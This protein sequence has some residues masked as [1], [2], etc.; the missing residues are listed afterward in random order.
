MNL[1]WGGLSDVF[2][3]HATL[4]GGHDENGFVFTVDENGKVVFVSDVATGFDVEVS[5]EFSFLSGLDGH[6]DV[7]EDVGGVGLHL[8][9]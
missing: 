8:V 1:L 3:V 7:A 2:D 4:G 5:N 9:F 6:Q